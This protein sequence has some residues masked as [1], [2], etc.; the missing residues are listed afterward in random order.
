MYSIYKYTNILVL[1][2]TLNISKIDYVRCN[3]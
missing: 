1:A 2:N 3:D